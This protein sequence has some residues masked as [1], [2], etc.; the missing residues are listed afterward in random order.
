LALQLAANR[1]FDEVLQHLYSI[2][3]PNP[4]YRMQVSGFKD[5]AYYAIHPTV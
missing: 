3:L 2:V 1:N 5:M 4:K